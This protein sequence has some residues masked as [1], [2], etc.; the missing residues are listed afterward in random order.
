MSEQ[1]VIVA[2]RIAELEAIQDEQ[3]RID[4]V[5]EDLSSGKHRYAVLDAWQLGELL[6]VSPG[7][8]QCGSW[9]HIQYAYKPDSEDDDDEDED[10]T[11][12]DLV[13]GPTLACKSVYAT[14]G[15]ELTFEATLSDGYVD[16]G[17]WS[18][19]DLKEGDGFDSSDFVT[20]DDNGK[21]SRW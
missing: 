3:A 21:P 11:E 12:D 2:S 9:T 7:D 16:G 20:L 10:A 8:A 14:S 18:P 13:R 15:V 6:G 1:D 4:R 19:Y 5:A 17:A